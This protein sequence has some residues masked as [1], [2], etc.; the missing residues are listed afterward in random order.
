M[1][2]KSDKIGSKKYRD[3]SAAN[4]RLALWKEYAK[5]FLGFTN[6]LSN[7]KLVI[8]FNKWVVDKEY[9][10]T[11]AKK[12]GL[13]FNDHSM[14]SVSEYGKGSSFDG[15]KFHGQADRMKVLERWKEFE[16]DKFYKSIF[17]DDEALSLSK[18]IFGDITYA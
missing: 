17:H 8:N 7:N 11:L 14:S 15:L 13:N 2:K 5:E 3:A 9:R 6:Y 1:L 10:R 12:L 18:E 16:S 4:A